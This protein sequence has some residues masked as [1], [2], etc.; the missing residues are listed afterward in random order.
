MGVSEKPGFFSKVMH[1]LA[2]KP[3]Q[4]EDIK[5]LKSQFLPEEEADPLE[6][7]FAKNFTNSGGKFL[8]CE[9][10]GQVI[11]T[12]KD[13]IA[14][15]QINSLY[16]NDSYLSQCFD[17]ISFEN[18]TNIPGNAMAY[19]INC[20][21]LVGFNGSVMISSN[22][23]KSLK[24]EELPP[25]FI[26]IARLEQLVE[27][28]NDALTGIR[29]KYKGNIPT[30]ITTLKGPRAE[31]ITQDSKNQATHKNIYLIVV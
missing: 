27:K 28:L 18:F 8:Y 7:R 19:A 1:I 2:G 14:E 23:T 6:V 20:E 9:D 26:V 16:C 3:A 5:P 15:E 17:K 25:I 11:A 29:D 13:I 31:G 12:I 4:E 22:Q 10:E 24:L 21:Y 30:G